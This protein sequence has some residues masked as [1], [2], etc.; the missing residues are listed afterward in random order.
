MQLVLAGISIRIPEEWGLELDE[1]CRPSVALPC[2]T[3][4]ARATRGDE[5]NDSAPPT[6]ASCTH[7]VNPSL[8]AAARRDPFSS[9]GKQATA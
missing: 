1:W 5:P 9:F 3:N 6:A 7:A 8:D 4:A 2:P